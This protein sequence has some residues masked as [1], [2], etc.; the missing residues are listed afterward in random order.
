MLKSISSI[1]F[2]LDLS[3]AFVMKV[4]VHSAIQSAIL[5]SLD[6]FPHCFLSRFSLF[7]FGKIILRFLSA[8]LNVA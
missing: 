4:I 3:H 5:P 6:I 8:A 2:A 7:S 1:L